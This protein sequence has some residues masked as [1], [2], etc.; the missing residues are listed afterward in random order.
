MGFPTW[1][2]GADAVARTLEHR[3]AAVMPPFG[4]PG[5]QATTEAL[6]TPATAR[7]IVEGGARHR[8]H[9]P[10]PSAA[11]RGS[12]RTIQS[13]SPPRCA[14]AALSAALATQAA[15]DE[16]VSPTV[17]DS[18]SAQAQPGPSDDTTQ[19]TRARDTTGRR[20]RFPA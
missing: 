11:A 8:A 20:I 3:P 6:I 1:A 19:A 2:I 14:P 17:S 12:S 7:A 13:G 16:T 4:D 18:A 15:G 9:L 5:L 10:A